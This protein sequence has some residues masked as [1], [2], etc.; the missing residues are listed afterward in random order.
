MHTL[1]KVSRLKKYF[2]VSSGLFRRVKG[3]VQ[4][5]DDVSFDIETGETLGLVGE[6]GCGKT[7]IA[8]LILRLIDPTDGT[9][10][11]DGKNITELKP[12]ARELRRIRRNMQI[13]FQ[14]PLASLNPR[15]TVRQILS[16]PYKLYKKEVNHKESIEEMILKLLE[17]VGLSPAELYIDRYPHEFSGGQRQRIGIARAVALQPKFVV[18]DE[19]VS[20][21]D[22]SIRA[23]ILNLMRRLQNNMQLSCL[24]VTHDLAVV[25]SVCHKVAVMYLGKIIEMSEVAALFGEPMHPYTRGLLSAT[26]IPDPK[27]VQKRI[28]TILKGE[29]PSSINPPKGC[30]FHTRC[31][32]CKTLCTK[33]D[34]QLVKYRSNHFVACHDVSIK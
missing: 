34:P 30:R 31:P 33:E 15:K 19:P 2:P 9:I 27:L 17:T 6:S 23:Q 4:A 21:L 24:F 10:L 5:V 22:I 1:V 25:R 18:A 16:R 7:T 3:W 32:N 12:R 28:R 8:R 29:I 20:S 14:D 13:V 11:F 26:P